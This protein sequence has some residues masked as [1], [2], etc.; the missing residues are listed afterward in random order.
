[1][2]DLKQLAKM[3]EELQYESSSI[4]KEEILYRYPELKEI[5]AIVYNPLVKFNITRDTIEKEKFYTPQIQIINV[6]TLIK[7][8]QTLIE[9][10]LNFSW[11]LYNLC[12][13]FIAENINYKET[14]LRVLDKDLKCGVSTKT[15]NK[16]FPKLIPE[17][18][19]PLASNYKE[20]MC[21]F[22][23]DTW[24]LS[25][26][27]DGIRCLVFF[28]NGDIRFF[29]RN[30]K[31]FYTLGNL[32][33]ELLKIEPI[34]DNTILDG[35]ICIVDEN[36]NEDFQTIMSQIRRKDYIIPNPKFYIFDVYSVKSFQ[37]KTCT[38][39]LY[40]KRLH[41]VK[42][43]SKHLNKDRIEVLEQTQIKD[44]KLF[45]SIPKHYEGFILRKEG[46]THF[47]RSKSLLKVK[48]FK[49][50]E[51]KVIDLKQ[52]TKV[53]DGI[54]KQI[55]SSLTIKYKDNIVD[56]GSGLSDKQRL[57]WV[58]RS[59]IIVGKKITVQ[60]FSESIDKNGD[61]SLR[62]PTLKHVWEDEK[63]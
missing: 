5:L 16:V 28:I 19:V 44:D 43:F 46:P 20:G 6:D 32:K 25:R 24:Y 35:E 14:I 34:L 22:E 42:K 8:I 18:N 39:S 15:I 63:E 50:D 55:V 12:M 10:D 49:E 37:E 17:F 53:I 23:K 62:F 47:K 51:F 52:G 54:E 38:H 40:S 26:K 13:N 4:M 58:N 31:E 2:E 36:G 57:E 3:I 41:F 21:D 27:L 56:V 29:S 30:G 60:Y 59:Y 61:V 7:F 48:K 9:K 33:Q 45:E 1:M 11:E